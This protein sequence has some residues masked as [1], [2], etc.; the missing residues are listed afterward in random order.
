M[1]LLQYDKLPLREQ[2]TLLLK[3]L[4]IAPDRIEALQSG[5]LLLSEVLQERIDEVFSNDADTSQCA[6]VCRNIRAD[7]VSYETL[8]PIPYLEHINELKA[9]GGSFADDIDFFNT[10]MNP[11]GDV[12][13]ISGPYSGPSGDFHGNSGAYGN[14]SCGSDTRI[15]AGSNRQDNSGS[16]T[17]SGGIPGSDEYGAYGNSNYGYGSSYGYDS[18]Y[19]S[20]IN[21]RPFVRYFARLVDQSIYMLLINLVFRLLLGTNPMY[22]YNIQA[23]WAVLIYIVMLA[24]EPLLLH[25]FATTPGKLIFGIRI[26]APDGNKLS[27]SQAY[28]RSFRLLRFGLGFIIPFYNIFRIVKSFADCKQGRILPWDFN[29]KI[30]KPEQT[31]IARSVIFIASFMILAGADTVIG[32]MCEMPSNRGELTEEQFYANCADIVKYDSITFSEVP[33]YRVTSVNGKVKSVSLTVES[34]DANTINSCFEQ[35]M[36]AYLAFVGAQKDAGIFEIN[37]GISQKYLTNCFSNFSFEYAG[38]VTTNTV[39]Y[40]GYARNILA[41]YLYQTSDSDVHTYK[42]VFTMELK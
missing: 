10:R 32:M 36:V 40:V 19:A 28:L 16:A 23:A 34:S 2:K 9:K 25:C 12:R 30:E 33:D 22:N 5:Q 21:P 14:G 39:E 35:I 31:T 1:K 20:M 4:G 7:R 29:T 41:N 24:I 27:L 18:N 37:Y 3:T 13:S 38:V 17:G 8:D 15:D 42:Q 6:I 26:T 11:N